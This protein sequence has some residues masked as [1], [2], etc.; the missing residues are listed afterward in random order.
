MKSFFK[1]GTLLLGI[2]LFSLGVYANPNSTTDMNT[3][4]CVKEVGT[5][6]KDKA[7]KLYRGLQSVVIVACKRAG[8]DQPLILNFSSLDKK[9]KGQLNVANDG[10]CGSVGGQ[11]IW[12]SGNGVPYTVW[13]CSSSDSN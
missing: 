9:N 8:T 13:I 1:I 5:V 7:R 6:E 3:N 4:G 11:D 10:Q 2:S 12:L